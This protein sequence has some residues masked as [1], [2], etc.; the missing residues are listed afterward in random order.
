MKIDMLPPSFFVNVYCSVQSS[1]LNCHFQFQYPKEL[2]AYIT[3][4]NLKQFL[5]EIGYFDPLRMEIC[6]F[7]N[8]SAIIIQKDLDH[9]NLANV[10]FGTR[11]RDDSIF[12][13]IQEMHPLVRLYKLYYSH[14]GFTTLRMDRMIKEWIPVFE[15]AKR[16]PHTMDIIQNA[17]SLF[18]KGFH[19]F[20]V[21][22][23]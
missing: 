14:G 16:F 21:G 11:N 4:R 12:L 23:L 15:E 18:V 17:S 20:S 7:V 9:Q 22:V 3:I 19:F 10:F 2:L 8:S 13:M 5:I 6:A 1:K